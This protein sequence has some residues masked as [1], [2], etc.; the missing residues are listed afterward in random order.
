MTD[1][2][3]LSE[4]RASLIVVAAYRAIN[5]DCVTVRD[6][7]GKEQTRRLRAFLSA[8][9]AVSKLVPGVWTEISPAIELE[10]GGA[11]YIVG[12]AR[13]VKP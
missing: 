5:S 11:G 9:P 8:W 4:Q 1:P 13:T 10:L 2:H 7:S 6:A 3:I 12:K